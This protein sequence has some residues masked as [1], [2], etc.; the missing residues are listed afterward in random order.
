MDE[1]LAAYLERIRSVGEATGERTGHRIASALLSFAMGMYDRAAERCDQSIEALGRIGAKDA[2]ITA[3]RILGGQARSLVA[4]QVSVRS[5][6]TFEGTEKGG[7]ITEGG[8][9]LP[10]DIAF[11]EED[12]ELLLFPEPEKEAPPDVVARDNALILLFAVAYT[13]SVD[14][15]QALEEQV[16]PLVLARLEHY[17]AKT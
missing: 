7:S 16:Y 8:E 3:L 4:T 11:G 13:A 2:V 9:G 17:R 14:D 10:D 5:E 6:F 1:E 12:R 15:V